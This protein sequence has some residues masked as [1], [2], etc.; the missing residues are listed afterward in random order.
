MH[1]SP[2]V[3]CPRLPCV[4][5]ASGAQAGATA[6]YLREWC[7]GRCHRRLLTRVVLRPVPPQVTYASGAQAGATAGYLREWCTCRCH[8]RLLTRVV[9]RPAPPQVTYAS[10][11]QAGATAGYLPTRVVHRPVP[12]Q[13]RCT[14][15]HRCKN[16]LNN[17]LLGPHMYRITCTDLASLQPSLAE[18]TKRVRSDQ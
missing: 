4:T 9:H 8:R 6:G 2:C 7:T 18:F 14:N 10:V 15:Y 13:V 5:Y 11:A 1:T 3:D 17:S 16:Q 12:P